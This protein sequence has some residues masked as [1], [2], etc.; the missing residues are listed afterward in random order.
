MQFTGKLIARFR[1]EVAEPRKQELFRLFPQLVLYINERRIKVSGNLTDRR[2]SQLERPDELQHTGGYYQNGE[3][4]SAQL[5]DGKGAVLGD[6]IKGGE[7]RGGHV[8]GFNAQG[9]KRRFIARHNFK[10]R[11]R[12]HD[13]VLFV[14]SVRGLRKVAKSSDFDIVGHALLQPK[15]HEGTLLPG[16]RRK[17]VEIEHPHA[18]AGIRK[19]QGGVAPA[20]CAIERN[21]RAHRGCKPVRLQNVVTQ[22]RNGN[23]AGFERPEGELRIFART[24]H[25]DARLG[26]LECHARGWVAPEGAQKSNKTHQPSINVTLLISL[27]VVVPV[28]TLRSADSRRNVIPS[29]RAR[30]LISEAGRL[31]RIIS[32]IRSVRSRSS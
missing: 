27:S 7:S 4:V 21:Q 16:V 32:R 11:D 14:F 5:G 8:T 19:D 10:R 26:E 17:I 24:R 1:A 12:D 15:L 23:D 30:R 13:I 29:S 6:Q 9:T 28:L 31:S 22:G 3:H 18:G 25:G 20:A 2:I